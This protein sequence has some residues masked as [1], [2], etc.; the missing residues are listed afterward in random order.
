MRRHLSHKMSTILSVFINRHRSAFHVNYVFLVKRIY[1]GGT[2][3]LYVHKTSVMKIIGG[4]YTSTV[5]EYCFPSI[6]N[7]IAFFTFTA[8]VI[9][10]ANLC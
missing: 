6:T 9:Y 3:K 2:D 4:P 7:M 1:R 10:T 5:M 8:V